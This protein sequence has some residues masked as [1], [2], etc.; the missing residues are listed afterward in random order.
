[1]LSV[2][3]LRCGGAASC[4]APHLC[5]KKPRLSS[6]ACKSPPGMYSI[7]KKS[8][9][10]VCARTNEADCGCPTVIRRAER[11]YRAPSASASPALA[12]ASRQS[13]SCAPP[14]PARRFGG[15]RGGATKRRDGEG[16]NPNTSAAQGRRSL[17]DGAK[18]TVLQQPRSKASSRS[19]RL[20]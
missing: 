3:A 9:L 15:G 2:C 10:R 8:R 6:V 17:Q 5:G 19:T 7:T 18:V 13:Q 1:M 11:G 20:D 16:R 14:V 12:A 4:A